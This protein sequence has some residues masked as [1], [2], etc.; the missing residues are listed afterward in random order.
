VPN[1]YNTYKNLAL[2]YQQKGQI[3]EAVAAAQRA[4]DLAPEDDKASLE[5]FLRQLQQLQG[6]TPESIGTSEKGGALPPEERNG[7]YAA[8]PPMTIDPTKSYRATIVTEKG[9]I[10]V[11]L[12]AGRAPNTV[13]N[14]VFLAREGFYDNT[15]FHRVIPGFMAQGGDPTGTGGGGPGYTFADEFDP[16]LRHDGPGVVS[17]ANAGPG[18]N[19][20]QF[21]ITYD[22]TPWLD[23]RHSVFGRVVEG[24]DVLGSLAPRDPQENPDYPGDAILTIVIQEE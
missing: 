23:D 11:E 20:S 22:A 15:T 6:E 14:F 10:I 17:M 24:M 18:T 4:L 8:A 16:S 13:N 1:D 5:V 9:N 19:G 2:L 12:Y 7:M 21:F 3:D